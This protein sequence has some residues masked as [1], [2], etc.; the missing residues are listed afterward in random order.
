MLSREQ[1]LELELFDGG[2]VPALSVYLDTGPERQVKRSYRIVFKDLVKATRDRL[3][4]IEQENLEKEVERAQ[5]WLEEQEPRGNGLALFSCEPE[6]LWQ[7]SFLPFTVQDHLAFEPSADVGPLLEIMEDFERTAVV[8]VNKERARIF[9]IAQGEI[10]ESKTHEDFVPPKNRRSIYE[11]HHQAHVYWHLKHVVE[12][13]NVLF[14]SRSFD[15]LILAGPEEVTSE[16]RR[17]LPRSLAS[18]L[19]ATTSHLAVS[20]TPAEVLE[21]TLEI[22]RQ[23]EQQA[24]TD[25]VHELLEIAGAGGLATMGV[26][27]T[28]EAI[29]LDE[30]L[31]LVV[32]EGSHPNGSECENCGWLQ[33]G[34]REI[35]PVCAADMHPIHDVGHRAMARAHLQAASVE[36]VHGKAAQTLRDRGA[37]LAAFLRFKAPA[38]SDSAEAGSNGS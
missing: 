23:I 36:V 22:E 37:E 11:K 24:E 30:I 31:T 19:K 3:G 17:I 13:L 8:L 4:K 38:S 12:Q 14:Q 9:T 5:A 20:A 21:S 26:D 2:A 1:I 28:L 33:Q 16:L 7:A 35:C 18:R 32:A 15:R 34:H 25:L 27:Q 10:E 29:W 6:K